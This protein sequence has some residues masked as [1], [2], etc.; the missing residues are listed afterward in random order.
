M[1]KTLVISVVAMLTIMSMVLVGCKASGALT[2]PIGLNA[3][4]TGGLPVVGASCKNGALLAV[5]EVNDAGGL[6]V[7]GKQYQIKLFVEDNGYKADQSVAVSQ[8]LISQDNVVAIIGPNASVMAV[9][10]SEIAESSKVL[11]ISPWSTNP[12]TTIDSKTGQPKKYVF[13]ACFIDTFQAKV[14]AKFAMEKLGAKRVAILY[15]VA[16]DAF[17][18]QSKFFKES[19]EQM[20]GTIVAFETYT[21]GDKDFSA[22]F[23]K[24]KRSNPDLIFL[25]S[26]YN[27]AP[28]QIK[29]AHALGITVP[30]LGTDGWTSEEMIKLGGK[31]VEGCFFS[32]HYAPDIA[33]PIAQKF[34]TSYKT[35][36]GTV[37]DD[38]AALTYDSFGL[39]FDALKTAGKVDRQAVHDALA[40]TSAYQGVTGTIQFKEGSGDPIKSAVMLQIKNGEFVYYSTAQ[41]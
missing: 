3:E 24:I 16:N 35:A 40:T 30:F 15:D 17:V 7:G 39:L 27:E 36:Y 37:P 14:D 29:Q 28:I 34:I 22:Q 6:T 31:D 4:L 20:G 23:T 21:T 2:I 5:K 11:M 10:A 8:K 18:G 33:T 25:P 1:K 26:M 12:N 32:G 9:P 41:P 19:F 13:R 38:V